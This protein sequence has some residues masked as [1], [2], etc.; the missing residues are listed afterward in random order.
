MLAWRPLASHSHWLTAL[1][2]SAA[3]ELSN[4]EE[5]LEHGSN[6]RRIGE[7]M[8]RDLSIPMK[9]Q[10]SNVEHAAADVAHGHILM[11]VA[12]CAAPPSS[13]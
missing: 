8:E 13:I 6:S 5:I 2:A 3:L 1:A 7:K 11:R 10:E 4:S 12:I 9:S